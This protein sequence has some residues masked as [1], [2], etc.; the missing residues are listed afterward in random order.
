MC[1]VRDFTWLLDRFL[2][3]EGWGVAFAS[4]SFAL[5][6]RLSRTLVKPCYAKVALLPATSSANFHPKKVNRLIEAEH[7]DML[8]QDHPMTLADVYNY[9]DRDYVPEKRKV[10]F[11]GR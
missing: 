11:S 1:K 10:G 7:L 4:S 5:S 3:K 2:E 6:M 8:P 9:H